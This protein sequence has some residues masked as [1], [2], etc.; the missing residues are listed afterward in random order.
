MG[1]DNVSSSYGVIGFILAIIS[2]VLLALLI[3]SIL[4]GAMFNYILLLVGVVSLILCA[5]QVKKNKS[6]L[7]IIGLVISILVILAGIFY[8]FSDWYT[9]RTVNNILENNRLQ[10]EA[11]N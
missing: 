1:D 11:K 6:R 10:I 4:R 2:L 8:I 9:T 7:A 3:L 5:I